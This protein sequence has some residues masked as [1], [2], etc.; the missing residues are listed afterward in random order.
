MTEESAC[1]L[2]DIDA[3]KRGAL[4]VMALVLKS[5]KNRLEAEHSFFRKIRKMLGAEP[6]S[7]PIDVETHKTLALKYMGG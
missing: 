6:V 2:L 7:V 5:D 1:R 4:V 3:A